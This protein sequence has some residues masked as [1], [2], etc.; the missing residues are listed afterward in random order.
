LYQSIHLH[1]FVFVVLTIEILLILAA[2][3]FAQSVPGLGALAIV[4]YYS[5]SMRRVFG[6]PRL[7][8]AWKG[9]L[10]G[11]TYVLLI[12]STMVAVG[13]WSVKEVEQPTRVQETPK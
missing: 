11:I 5:L 1:S 10:I 13:L 2:P 12:F 9:T 6:G 4:I 3:P 8:T 7:A